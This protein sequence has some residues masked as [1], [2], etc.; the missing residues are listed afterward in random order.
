[1]KKNF[2]FLF[3]C[4]LSLE[5]LKAQTFV[6]GGIYSNTTWTLSNSP[7][8]LTGNMVVFPGKTLTIEPGV[9]VLVKYD[10]IPN[11]GSMYY[12][13]IRGSLNAIGTQNQPIVFKSDTL[14]TEQTWL[15]INVKGTQGGQLNIDYIELS[16]AFYGIYA[17]NQVAPLLNLHHCK[18]T[19]NNYAIQPFGPINFYDCSFQYNG[20]GIASNW[21][22]NHQINLLRCEFVN[23]YSCN[24]FQDQ[25]NVDSC[26]IRGNVNG[27]WYTGGSITN[28]QFDQNAFAIYAVTSNISNCSFNQNYKGLMEFQGTANNCSFTNNGTA[29]EVAAAGVVTNSTFYEDTIAISYASTLNASSIIP[30]VLNNRICESINYYVENK[31]DLNFQLDQNCF[32]ETDSTVIENLIYDGYDDIT[33][34]LFNYTVYDSTCVNAIRQV[35]KIMLVTSLESNLKEDLAVYPIPAGNQ[36]FLKVPENLINK[37][38]NATL[39]DALGRQKSDVKVINQNNLAW[40]LT[41]LPQGLYF[42]RISDEYATT[43]KFIK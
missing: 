39:F 4:F 33:K 26:L 10:G 9:E 18:F 35:T 1:M 2:V 11:T 19:Y 24:G 36:V 14:P 28:T 21:Q 37:S 6:N 27:I 42:I 15:G 31:S 40:D 43:I 13:E 17:D 12:L 8:V 34:G 7:Y 22:I 41:N 5:L 29:A 23:N 32:C 3:L 16:N 38:M 30:T 20:Q 25:I